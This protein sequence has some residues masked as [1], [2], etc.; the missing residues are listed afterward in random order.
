MTPQ[1]A[2]IIAG[3]EPTEGRKSIPMEFRVST[4]AGVV[5]DL[6]PQALQGQFK[7]A[8]TL[9]V[10]NADN[11]FQITIINNI[12][13]QR[14]VIQPNSQG[15]YQLLINSPPRLN[16]FAATIPATI[17]IQILNFFIDPVTWSVNAGNP[18][19][20]PNQIALPHNDILVG[21]AAGQAVAVPMSGDASIIDTGA[22]TVLSASDA[23]GFSVPNGPITPSKTKGILGT[24]TNSDAP[25]GAIGES[26]LTTLSVATPLVNVT[27]KSILFLD[28]TPGDWRV[29]GIIGFYGDTTTTINTLLASITPNINSNGTFGTFNRSEITPKG[30]SPFSINGISVLSGPLRVSLSVATRYYLTAYA[31]FGTS[32]C[33]AIGQLSAVRSQNAG[34]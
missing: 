23:S 34:I 33:N 5:V 13:G 24:N 7:S 6:I 32:F 30:T 26:F 8:Q 21:D 18:V 29:N 20:N 9:Y 15:Y 19:I 28:L 11:D 31:D 10:D 3:R 12:T 2:S 1:I 25:A 4:T 14:F 17:K 27:A 22:I 16:F